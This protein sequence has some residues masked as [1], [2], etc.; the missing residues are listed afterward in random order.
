LLETLWRELHS[1]FTFD[2]GP[3]YDDMRQNALLTLFTKLH[4]FDAERGRAFNWCTTL[5]LNEWR[6]SYSKEKRQEVIR[7]RLTERAVADEEARRR[8]RG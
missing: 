1:R 7:A 5:I 8:R 3:G 2:G 4:K 6:S